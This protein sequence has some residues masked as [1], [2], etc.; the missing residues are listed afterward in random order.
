MFFFITQSGTTATLKTKE[1]GCAAR[2]ANQKE[3][4]RKI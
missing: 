2:S 4:L 1:M 3:T